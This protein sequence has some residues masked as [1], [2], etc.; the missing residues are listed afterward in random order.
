MTTLSKRCLDILVAFSA[1]VFLMPLMAFISILVLVVDKAPVFFLQERICQAG[2]SFTLLKFRTMRTGP[3]PAVTSL[4]DQR[5]TTLGGWLRRHKL[6]ELPQFLHVLTGTMSLVGPRPEVPQFIDHG[7]PDQAIVLSVRPGLVDPAV[8]TYLNEE[9]TLRGV[10]DPEQHY[11][12][13]LRPA[14]LSL[15]AR[16]VETAGFWSD[17]R[18]LCSATW[19]IFGLGN[20]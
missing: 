7:N 8:L 13:T 18:L 1:L 5:K 9:E 11:C 16:Y 20:S 2:R 6:D 3:G 14:K 15:S 12:D 19:R 4:D 10:L 17:V